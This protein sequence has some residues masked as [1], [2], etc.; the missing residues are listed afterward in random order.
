MRT[1]FTMAGIEIPSEQLATILAHPDMP[2]TG[3]NKL[4]RSGSEQE[5]DALRAAWV[6][7]G[8]RLDVEEALRA[9]GLLEEA[10]GDWRGAGAF[11]RLDIAHAPGIAWYTPIYNGIEMP[12]REEISYEEVIAK[13]S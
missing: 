10:R 2:G 13:F 5:W 8:A 6:L 9:R 4:G 12:G 3:G 7:A 1:T 11:V